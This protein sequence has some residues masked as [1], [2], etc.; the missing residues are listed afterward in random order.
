MH[1]FWREGQCRAGSPKEDATA[2]KE[3]V[4]FLEGGTVACRTR[5]QELMLSDALQ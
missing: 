4:A 3:D 5:L 1:H 2:E